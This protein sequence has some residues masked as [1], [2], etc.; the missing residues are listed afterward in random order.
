M[1]KVCFDVYQ[2]NELDEKAK[3]VARRWMRECLREDSGWY[4]V[5][6]EDANQVAA[7]L[8]ITIADKPVRTVGGT[9]RYIPSIWFTGFSS[10]GDG[11]CFEGSYRYA[12]T[13]AAIKAYA[14][15]DKELERIA[16]GLELIQSQHRNG[17]RATM[18]QRGS[19]LHSGCMDV[20]V[21]HEDDEVEV[22]DGAERELRDLMR[23]FADWIYK[24]LEA[25]SD[26]RDTD[27][28]VDAQIE[29]NEYEFT[30]TG[31]RSALID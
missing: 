20:E 23:A 3:E 21:T 28:Y 7:I 8:G 19:Y 1:R 12:P 14:P 2:F 30:A 22:S 15:E 27:A 11:A 16:M 13:I 6:Y 4:D 18:V 17:L 31:K 24:Q 29:A 5:V 25:E 26:H 10:Q 9:T